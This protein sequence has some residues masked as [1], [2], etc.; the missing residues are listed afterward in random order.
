V[1]IGSYPDRDGA[2]AA[3]QEMEEKTGIKAIIR[4]VGRF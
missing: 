2:R 3:V 1:R 4:P